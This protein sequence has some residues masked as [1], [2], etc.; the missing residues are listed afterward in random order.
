MQ[1]KLL[2]LLRS[3]T[4]NCDNIEKLG[5][6]GVGIVKFQLRE[7]IKL[8]EEVDRVSDLLEWEQDTTA[9]LKDHIKELEDE[10]IGM[11]TRCDSLI[12]SSNERI[13]ALEEKPKST[14]CAYCGHEVQIDDDAATKISEHI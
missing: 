1:E 10:L 6:V 12:C 14:W 9:K 4:I 3:A 7:A 8:A 13:K 5:N 11:Q 2:E